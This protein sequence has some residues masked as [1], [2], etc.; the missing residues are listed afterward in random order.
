MEGCETNSV[1]T[2]IN[3]SSC[4]FRVEGQHMN[5]TGHIDFSFSLTS[6]VTTSDS[7]SGN[8]NI[9]KTTVNQIDT[10]QLSVD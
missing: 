6:R 7:Y 1:V 8:I 9:T 5:N 4:Q 2:N 10:R 3:L